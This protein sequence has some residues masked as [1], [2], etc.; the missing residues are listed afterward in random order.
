MYRIQDIFDQ[1]EE[2]F[3]FKFSIRRD[4]KEKLVFEAQ[5]PLLY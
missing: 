3:D 1:L 4:I 2:K 5:V